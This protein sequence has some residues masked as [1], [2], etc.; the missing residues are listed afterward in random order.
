MFLKEVRGRECTEEDERNCR[1]ILS[2][3]GARTLLSVGSPSSI[4]LSKAVT[5]A[6]SSQI[7]HTI[8]APTTLS[9][10]LKAASVGGE[11]LDVKEEALVPFGGEKFGEFGVDR[12]VCLDPGVIDDNHRDVQHAALTSAGIC[13][14]VMQNLPPPSPGN[15]EDEEEFE[16]RQTLA[17]VACTSA[18]EIILSSAHSDLSVSHAIS[19]LL[20]AGQLVQHGGLPF[21]SYRTLHVGVRSA[22]LPRYFPSA[23]VLDVAAG[24]FGGVVD[25]LGNEDIEKLGAGALSEIVRYAKDSSD[26]GGGLFSRIDT[27]NGLPLPADDE[28][29]RNEWL[30]NSAMVRGKNVWDGKVVVGLVRRMVEED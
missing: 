16:R 30:N 22:F 28:V 18:A 17:A 11:F 12:T 8:L 4:E 25:L 5:F 29:L 13:L 21:Q 26:S 3:T 10:V 7:T 23:G 24:L 1:E 14:D 19:S 2:R 6:P 20:H 9:G 15:V 27:S